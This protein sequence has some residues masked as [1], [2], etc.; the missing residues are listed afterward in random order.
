MTDTTLIQPFPTETVK[1]TYDG[2][3]Y[4]L[5]RE[6]TQDDDLLRQIMSANGLAGAA[7]ALVERQA[8][9]SILL[10]KRGGPNGTVLDVPVTAPEDEPSIGVIDP[11][12]VIAGV[13]TRLSQ[14]EPHINPAVQCDWELR[15]QEWRGTLAL[16]DLLMRQGVI[17]KAI[18]D[19]KAERSMVAGIASR[20]AACR[21]VPDQR[22]PGLM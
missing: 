19:G 8:D 21:S 4:N 20:L 1:V 14:L 9:G 2:K 7:N 18:T 12:S 3:D 6:F 16:T 15:Q 5:S 11:S 13:V 10:V 22:A 17:D